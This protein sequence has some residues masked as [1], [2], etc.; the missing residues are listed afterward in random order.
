MGIVETPLT[1]IVEDKY[2][3]CEPDPMLYFAYGGAIKHLL[4]LFP[5]IITCLR[6]I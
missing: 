2:A 3:I 4:S 1:Y 5:Q 6:W